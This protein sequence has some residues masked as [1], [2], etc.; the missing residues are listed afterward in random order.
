[1]QN[2][3]A[4]VDFMRHLCPPQKIH[5]FFAEAKKPSSELLEFLRDSVIQF[6]WWHHP[7]SAILSPFY[8]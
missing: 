7:T 2:F 4:V 5:F 8:I 6:V 1:M 3:R